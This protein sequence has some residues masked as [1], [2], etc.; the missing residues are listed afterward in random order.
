[1]TES[2]RTFTKFQFRAEE[3]YEY[4]SKISK[5]SVI[6]NWFSPFIKICIQHIFERLE[7]F[8]IVGFVQRPQLIKS[9]LEN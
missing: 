7:I 2:R 4:I 3:R 6:P 9:L 8:C 5:T 1:M